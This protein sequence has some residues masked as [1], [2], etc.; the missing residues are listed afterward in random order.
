MTAPMDSRS[1]YIQWLPTSFLGNP[2]GKSLDFDG[3]Q[4]LSNSDDRR[5]SRVGGRRAR[6]AHGTC[7]ETRLQR[8][9]GATFTDGRGA[10]EV[11]QRAG[12]PWMPPAVEE[13]EAARRRRLWTRLLVADKEPEVSIL[14]IT[15]ETRDRE[16]RETGHAGA[17]S[18]CRGL[19]A[20][21][22]KVARSPHNRGWS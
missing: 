18:G 21:G 17:V 10:P 11:A 20:R 12:G 13:S 5:D 1:F 6:C 16:E 8:N 4:I 19:Y 7:I 22:L 2:T 9:V 14:A 15:P 3:H